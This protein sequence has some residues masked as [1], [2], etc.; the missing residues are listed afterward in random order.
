MTVL[1]LTAVAVACLALIE[2]L[3]GHDCVGDGCV[4]C[5]YDARYG[6]APDDWQHF[7]DI[8]DD[9]TLYFRMK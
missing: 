6:V 2:A 5:L 7:Y 3:H 4:F 1:V 9:H 8:A